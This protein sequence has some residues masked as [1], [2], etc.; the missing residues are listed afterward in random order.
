[1]RKFDKAE[2]IARDHLLHAAVAI[3]S[4]RDYAFVRRKFNGT[5]FRALPVRN[6]DDLLLMSTM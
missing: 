2:F 5:S 1:M 3:H 6:T 4:K